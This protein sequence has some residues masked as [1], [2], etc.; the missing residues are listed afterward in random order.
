MN[1]FVQNLKINGCKNIDKEIN[2][3][4]YN[5]TLS[6]NIDLQNSSIK[7]IYGPN[8][9]GK[10]GIMSALYIY[11]RLLCEKNSL[12]D[13]YFRNF[14]AECINKYNNKLSIK[15][16]LLNFDDYDVY[17]CTIKHEITLEKNNYGVKIVEEKISEL[18]G[19]RIKEDK[20]KDNIVIKL[21]TIENIINDD[22]NLIKNNSMNLLDN[23][24][25][26]AAVENL[27]LQ[28]YEVKKWT[29]LLD[30]FVLKLF[31]IELTVELNKEDKHLDYLSNKQFL[32]DMVDKTKFYYEILNKQIN[33]KLELSAIYDDVIP[34]EKFNEYEKMI[35]N[36]SSFIKIFKPDL[37]RIE[38]DKK[39]NDKVYKCKKI[40]IYDNYP[41]DMEFESTGIKKLVRLYTNF[42]KYVNGGVVFIDEMD[43]NLHDVYFTKLIEFF[44]YEAKGQL[45]FTTHNLEPIDVL[46]DNKY[47]LEFLSNDS[48]I[49]SWVK[50]GRQSP[51]NKYVNG[52]IPYSTFNVDSTNFE[53]LLED[54]NE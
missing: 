5:N 13:S 40:F 23:N 34:V 38:I 25:I 28:N 2:I 33:D 6:N 43:A 10:S 37:K 1:F 42:K 9:A 22:N 29:T 54:S 53:V 39:I 21:G 50:G 4:F 8:G 48:R 36:L 31:A 3:N 52:L 32:E 30:L 35:D 19:R 44:K 24:S 46:K 41:I 12:N 20:F 45:C 16:T 17:Q 27:Y 15:I 26:V 49:A 7:A 51:M 18:S 14:V 11:K 47:A